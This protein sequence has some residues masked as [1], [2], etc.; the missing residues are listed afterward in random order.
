L[1]ILRHARL[2]LVLMTNSSER[3]RCS[4]QDGEVSMHLA[5][6]S[7]HIP[8]HL[9]NESKV[10]LDAL[11]STGTSSLTSSFTLA[12]PVEWLQAWV[13][14]YVREEVRLGNADLEVLMN[15]L[16]VCFSQLPESSRPAYLLLL[17]SLCLSPPQRQSRA[18]VLQ[19]SRTS[20]SAC[21]P[22]SFLVHWNA[23]RV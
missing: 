5:D 20:R 8:A 17:M 4:V 13:S 23:V 14:C 15:C 22:P 11:T 19:E 7:L 2:R 21:H 1:R 9:V 3:V 6:V 12:A 16:R 10:L 18:I